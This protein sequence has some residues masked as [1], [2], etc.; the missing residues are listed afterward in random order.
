[1]PELGPGGGKLLGYWGVIQQSVAQRLSTAELWQSVREAAA[2]DGY[3]I[4]G[5]GAIDMGTLRSLAA[6]QREADAMLA[7]ASP[8]VGLQ[9]SMIGT[10]L[11]GFLRP[12]ASA[13]PQWL[14]RFQHNTI[15][16]GQDV[17]HWRTSLFTGAL[18]PTKADLLAQLDADGE[19]LSQDYNSD[20][21]SIGDVAISQL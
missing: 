3:D 10:D 12:N 16:D 7:R 19:L 5:A 4:S 17:Q 15:E 1:M 8:D 9:A 2:A 11:A 21:I 14:V 20:H 18:P 13:S 6:S